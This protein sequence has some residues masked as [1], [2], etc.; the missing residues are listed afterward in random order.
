MTND[1]IAAVSTPVGQGG[2]GIVRVSGPDALGVG[3]S[4]FSSRGCLKNRLTDFKERRFYYGAFTDPSGGPAADDGFFV[5][6]KGPASY[7]GEDVVELHCHGGAL[8]VKKCLEVVLKAGARLAGPGEFTK[9]A[10]LNGKLDLAQAEA[11]IDVIRASTEGALNSAR[12]RLEGGLSKKVNAIKE[13]LIEM[14]AHLEAGL[15]F[16][17]D[18][19]R[20]PEGLLKGLEAAEDLIK[21][22]LA[23][24]EEGM[25]LR[26]GIKTLILGRTNAGKSSLLNV[27]LEAERAIVT[28]E[29]GTT[30]D[31]I[32]EVLNVRGI[33]VRLMDTAG[34]RAAAGRVE[35][36]GI[37]A[38]WRHAKDAGLILYVIDG[39]RPDGF[40]EDLKNLELIAGKKVL[41]VA[42]KTDIIT[43]KRRAEIQ[44]AF[45][46]NKAVFISALKE[47]G[48]S[49]LKEAICG[50]AL[51]HGLN[52]AGDNAGGDMIASVRH[53]DALGAA[54]ASL[55]QAKAA[56]SNGLAAEFIAVDLR[57]SINALGEITG[58]TTT[59]DI[60]DRIF[61]GFC[62]GK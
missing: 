17:D 34:L 57:Q 9:R 8:T 60:L 45:T 5:F 23:T 7:T 27:L 62:I 11:V 24:Y 35:S 46:G 40:T 36:I 53:K 55:K 3:R 21:E 61:S 47:E 33:A 50:A 38:A 2:I 12:R 59:E 14:L 18:V 25:I 42:N 43:G 51:G 44:E 32:E 31:V 4:V 1:T 37:K 56:A 15:D 58:E 29:H 13:P 52:K 6:M 49:E 41:I 30:R 28:E 19:E 22:L 10:F 39:S 16:P 26:E 20:M 54:L 48:I